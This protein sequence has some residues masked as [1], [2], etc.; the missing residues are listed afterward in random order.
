MAQFNFL[1][2][3][4]LAAV[5]A[6]TI[7]TQ[8]DVRI[9]RIYVPA[10]IFGTGGYEMQNDHASGDPQDVTAEQVEAAK[11]RLVAAGIPP[12]RMQTWMQPVKT[13]STMINQDKQVQVG[14]IMLDFGT[15]AEA[16]TLALL[17]PKL[18]SRNLEFG[19][20]QYVG[21]DCAA[22]DSRIA[23][24]LHARALETASA[25]RATVRK[26]S[27]TTDPRTG[28]FDPVPLCP[29]GLH[30]VVHS[31]GGTPPTWIRESFTRYASAS[32]EL[33]STTL[34]PD[35][36]T[37]P[38]ETTSFFPFSTFG[39][40]VPIIGHQNRAY[41]LHGGRFA[42]TPGASAISTTVDGVLVRYDYRD[43][44]KYASAAR[45]LEQAGIPPSDYLEEAADKQLYIRMHPVTKDRWASLPVLSQDNMDVYR[46]LKNCA[47]YETYAHE[48]A[49]GRS[50][51]LAQAAAD[52][53]QVHAGPLIV[54]TD[55]AGPSTN[56]T[57]GSNG[58]GDLRALVAFTKLNGRAGYADQPYS[59]SFWDSV[60]GA[61]TLGPHAPTI[62][63][64]GTVQRLVAVIR[65]DRQ[66]QPVTGT[67][68]ITP[69][70]YFYS[71]RDTND[72]T[73][74]VVAKSDAPKGKTLGNVITDCD[75]A[76]AHALAN[77]V[78]VAQLERAVNSFY[79]EPARL[80]S[81]ACLPEEDVGHTF[82]SLPTVYNDSSETGSAQVTQTI[83]VY[84]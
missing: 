35:A 15:P 52:T 37:P 69:D 5:S 14:I 16:R 79:A 41:V 76:Q 31:A 33:S 72:F 9:D 57:C 61:W 42:A 58:A 26:L 21:V 32:L 54:E 62:A 7:S 70:A 11:Q 29:L 77:A 34:A 68:T 18:R 48:L 25:G 27:M 49:R 44:A 43:S 4:I 83:T 38:P 80:L 6:L 59:A 20:N 36:A 63:S 67:A 74:T 30:P 66:G 12:Q 8:L 46:F 65:S 53:L 47:P 50:Y 56:A 55:W 81:I 13:Y 24:L 51:R 28:T 78:K 40:P 39:F 3:P 2:A 17:L 84:P 60:Y 64:E 45:T 1:F 23:A 71:G 73:T 19:W 75:A 10:V 22:M 82:S